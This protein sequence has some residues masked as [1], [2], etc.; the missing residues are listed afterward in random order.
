MDTQKVQQK[1]NEY[2]LFVE[3]KLKSDLKDIETILEDKSSKYKEWE[4]VQ[5][6]VKVIRNF[7]DKNRDMNVKVDIGKGLLAQGEITD[8][9]RSYINIGLGYMLE[10]DCDE[11]DKY[12][13]IRMNFLKKEI[14]HFRKL[15]IDVK[16]H[17][18]LTLLAI[19]ELQAT[20]V[21]SK[22]KK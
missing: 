22:Q 21:P 6:V 3:E 11:A 7:K 18:K 20:L 2:E 14:S 10:M 9:E 17:I 13:T 15:A 1:I 19:N 5:N 12:S 8:F 16:V 4:E